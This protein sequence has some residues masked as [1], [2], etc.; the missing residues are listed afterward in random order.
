MAIVRITRADRNDEFTFAHELGHVFDFYV[1]DPLGL[2][3][4]FAALEGF[5]WHTP[6]SE[7]YFAD[8][9]ALCALHRRLGRAVTTG[10]GFRV[11]PQLHRQICGLIR[12]AYVRWLAAPPASAPGQVLPL[13]PA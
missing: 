10:Y 1:L 4:S 12:N 11:S 9:Y 2:R 5:R 8:A 13:L 3:P 6:Q 7:E